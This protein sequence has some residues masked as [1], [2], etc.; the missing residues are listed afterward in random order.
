MTPVYTRATSSLQQRLRDPFAIAVIRIAGLR[1]IDRTT[2]PQIAGVIV[3]RISIRVNPLVPG[4]AR[5][6][7]RRYSE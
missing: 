1:A 2:R 7:L 6:R 5:Q 3:V 4:W